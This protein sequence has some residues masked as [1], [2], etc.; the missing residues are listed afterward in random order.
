MHLRRAHIA[1]PDLP[2]VLEYT[3]FVDFPDFIFF[4]VLLTGKETALVNCGKIDY[5]MERAV[6][7]HM[8]HFS[9]GIRM[10]AIDGVDREL[11]SIMEKIA[12]HC[13]SGKSQPKGG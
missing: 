5:V 8:E 9:E 13:I 11:D 2:I 10:A 7:L 1:R 6:P 3:G 12:E 4:V